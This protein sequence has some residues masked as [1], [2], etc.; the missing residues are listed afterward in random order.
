LHDG[1]LPGIGIGHTSHS[2]L[3]LH[4]RYDADLHIHATNHAA[5]VGVKLAW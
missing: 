1:A 4:A 5:T 3:M 2:G